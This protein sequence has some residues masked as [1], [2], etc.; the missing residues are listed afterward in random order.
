MGSGGSS[1]I[2][3]PIVH[4]RQAPVRFRFRYWLAVVLAVMAGS[5]P[6]AAEPPGPADR[7]T[8][9][10]RVVENWRE[11]QGVDGLLPY[12][13]DFLTGRATDEPTTRGYIVRQAGAFHAWA[14]YYDHS[15]DDRYREP[16][17]RGIA[18]LAER[19]LPMGKSPAQE[20]IEATRILLVPAGRRTLAAAL[21]KSGL[22]YE[23]TGPAKVVSADGQYSGAWTGTT[24][25]ALLAELTY[26]GASGDD[27]FAPFRSAWR[28]GLL[29]LRIPGGGFRESPTSIDESDYFN[30]EAWLAL[31]V[32][33][34]KH[35]DDERVRRALAE[36]EAVLMQRYSERPS[37]EFYLWGAMAA[38]QRWKTTSDP[39]FVAYLTRQ[40]EVFAD[41]FARQLDAN[42]NN[43]GAMEGL[44]ATL[45]VFAGSGTLPGDLPER[46]RTLLSREADKVPHL[47]IQPGQT[48]MMLGGGATLTA[49]ELPRFGGAF[50][51][52]L[53]TPMTRVD[54]AQHCLSALMM[55]DADDRLAP[56][57]SMRAPVK[58]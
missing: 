18:A 27:S 21:G 39:R 19:S 47:Q 11:T 41:R 31:A 6:C 24:A 3:K 29:A 16:L 8:I 28:D 15:R 26:S 10:R 30:G 54:A 32:Y 37:N 17:R 53:F 38:A 48:R 7:Q 1:P 43:C 42:A 12:G 52:G 4:S 45:Q 46:I 13:F 36:I 23:P 57:P 34:E 58:Q 40:S 14:K 55:I 56:A 44:A 50:L 35:R 49:P 22:L 9:M 2:E 20:W 51:A 5:L 33:A 25:L